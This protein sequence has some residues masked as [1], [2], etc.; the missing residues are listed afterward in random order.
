MARGTLKPRY[1]NRL[2][3]GNR[4]AARAVTARR[5]ELI[6]VGQALERN[7]LRY[8]SHGPT[9]LFSFKPQPISSPSCQGGRSAADE[10]EH[11][12]WAA[13]AAYGR[14]VRPFFWTSAQD[15]EKFLAVNR[16][17]LYAAGVW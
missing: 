5:T 15:A 16:C 11:Q 10:S 8:T 12:C 6:P 13:G 7:Q 1:Y 4:E 3:L 2:A 9:A 14:M 17:C